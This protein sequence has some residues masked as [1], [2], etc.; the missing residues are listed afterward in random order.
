MPSAP[1][2]GPAPFP[3]LSYSQPT[4]AGMTGSLPHR[5]RQG[6]A[7]L[8]DE[9]V[10][11]AQLMQLHGPALE[12]SM[13]V[14]MGAPCL[15]P[16]PGVG[17]V[18]GAALMLAAV[19]LWKGQGATAL[20]ARVAAFRLPPRW[21]HR[22]LRMLAAVYGWAERGSRERLVGLARPG[23]SPWLAT[24]VGLMGAVIFL[25]IP[26]GNVLPALAVVALGL[27][28]ALRD[29]VAVL[30]AA[31]LALSALLYTAALGAGAWWWIAAPLMHW[32]GRA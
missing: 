1:P 2:P 3:A 26:L 15:L 27:G 6:A 10:T 20:P 14:L 4:I 22:V 12:G 19:T 23:P 25:P 16:I 18:M 9:P 32:I 5:L 11:I 30:L 13:L 24:Q 28:L 21:A 17:N 8:A 29:G 31:G 7:Q